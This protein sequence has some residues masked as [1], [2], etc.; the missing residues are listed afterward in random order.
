M[1]DPPDSSLKSVAPRGWDWKRDKEGQVTWAS[2]TPVDANVAKQTTILVEPDTETSQVRFIPVLSAYNDNDSIRRDHNERLALFNDLATKINILNPSACEAFHTVSK[3]R[4][5]KTTFLYRGFNY[6]SDETAMNLSG[7][8]FRQAVPG[9]DTESRPH[10]LDHCAVGV[11]ANRYSLQRPETARRLF[12][13]V[14]AANV[15]IEVKESDDS[16]ASGQTDQMH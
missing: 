11:Q 5:E 16:C 10:Y 2:V 8:R 4:Q 6:L 3:S 7:M 9:L 13:Y 1:S 12:E 14:K 15:E